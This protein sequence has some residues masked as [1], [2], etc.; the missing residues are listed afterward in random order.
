M[1]PAPFTFSGLSPLY[2]AL[3]HSKIHCKAPDQWTECDDCTCYVGVQLLLEADCKVP[4]GYIW[5][6]TL[7][8]CSLKA[9]KL[10]FKH[11]KNRR[12]RL[13]NIALSILPERV[14]RQYGVATSL[15]PDKTSS[16][17]W[18]ELQEAQDQQDHRVWLPDS[19]NPCNNMLCIPESLFG[20][21][22]HLCVVEMALD[23]GFAP[24]DENGVQP[25]L[26][27]SHIIQDNSAEDSKVSIKYLDWL[28]SQNLCSEISLEPFRLSILHRIAVFIGNLITSR[29][30]DL[31]HQYVWVLKRPDFR[32]LLPAICD[33]KAQ[34]NIPCP[35]TSGIFTQPLAHVLPATLRHKDDSHR[36][37]FFSN[38]GDHIELVVIGIYRLELSESGS[39]CLYMAK[40]AIHILTMMS[41]GVRHLPICLT[42]GYDNLE[43]AM[44]N[45]DW[46]EM[47]D[48]DRKLIDQL[49]ALDEEFGDV[50]YRQNVSIAE[51]LSGYWLTR[52]EEVIQELHKPLTRHDRYE[53]LE[54][55]VVLEENN[56]DDSE[57]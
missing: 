4:A 27:G 16:L 1:G 47:L 44:G 14:L 21:P 9:R 3:I 51:F 37:Y 23:Y 11:L 28:L 20:V 22:H 46:K 43:R 45:E 13:R 41:L 12:Q 2:Y 10:F 32:A 56:A 29:D 50:F 33:S 8:D 49:E 7:A 38:I 55:G 34:C 53:L 48:E 18:S 6:I 17:L 57:C 35:C 24:R 52:M 5:G 54:A 39:E 19:L 26:S 25:L 31:R 15:L 30:S 42:R 36:G 40:C